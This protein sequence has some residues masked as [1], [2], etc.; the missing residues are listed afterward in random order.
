M[1]DKLTAQL[2]EAQY[3]QRAADERANQ[4]SAALKHKMREKDRKASLGD[5]ENM[6][7]REAE[8]AR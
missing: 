6:G 5:Q 8:L 3:Q 2:K 1:I 4:L 7:R